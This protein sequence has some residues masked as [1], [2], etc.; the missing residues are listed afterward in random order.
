[1]RPPTTTPKSSSSGLF[2]T[3]LGRAKTS[4]WEVE[5]ECKAQGNFSPGQGFLRVSPWWS[6]RKPRSAQASRGKLVLSETEAGLR[7]VDRKVLCLCH[8]QKPPCYLRP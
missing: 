1:M 3:Q 5:K 7:W 4:F 8:R 2:S 6:L